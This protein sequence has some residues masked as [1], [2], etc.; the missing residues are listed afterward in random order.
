[1]GGG[2][3]RSRCPP[4]VSIEPPRKRRFVL[5]MDPFP[6]VD[7]HT[8]LADPAFDEDRDEVIARARRAGARAVVCIGE[9]LAAAARA[10]EIS[11]AYPGFAFFTAGV[12]PH[13]AN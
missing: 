12:H 13:D 2:A 1:G 4:S 11:A 3:G 6:F 9:S 5:L 10:R 7:S 8:H